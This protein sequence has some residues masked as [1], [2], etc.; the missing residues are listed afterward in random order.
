MIRPMPGDELGRHVQ[1]VIPTALEQWDGADLMVRPDSILDVCHFLKKTPGLDFDLLISVSAV[2]YVEYFEIV[3][4][5]T[6]TVHSHSA[7]L[8][9]R[10]F[11]REQLVVPSVV[12]VWQGADFQEREVWDLMGIAF[13]GHPN[14]KRIMLWEG[15][16]GHPL[17][18][19]YLEPPR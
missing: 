1:V 16:S 12:S 13:A 4:H 8:K 7:V 2:D 17:R 18:R 19:D 15:F 3:Y 14:L 9:A 6:S 5:L 11:G 10:V